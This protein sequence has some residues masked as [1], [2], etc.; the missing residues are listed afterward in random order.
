MEKIKKILTDPK[1]AHYWQELNQEMMCEEV[2]KYNV[3]KAL[4][5]VGLSK[6][7]MTEYGESYYLMYVIREVGR[8]VEGIDFEWV[9]KDTLEMKECIQG[10]INTAKDSILY[11]LNRLLELRAI[12]ENVAEDVKV[13]LD[14]P[15]TEDGDYDFDFDF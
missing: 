5:E 12:S 13:A 9:N 1:L 11:N 8:S 6:R 14:L 7:L 15:E 10:D 2:T 3:T 4:K